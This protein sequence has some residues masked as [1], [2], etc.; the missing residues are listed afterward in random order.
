MDDEN[1]YG[2]SNEVIDKLEKDVAHAEIDAQ[3]AEEFLDACFP[4]LS[5]E[6][7]AKIAIFSEVYYEWF[8]SD[9]E[10]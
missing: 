4:A 9:E 5:P 1:L 10:D 2:L 7:K 8:G 3:T 6:V